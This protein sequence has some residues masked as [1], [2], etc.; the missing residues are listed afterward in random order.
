ML[1]MGNLMEVVIDVAGSGDNQGGLGYG[2]TEPNEFHVVGV[3]EKVVQNKT[4]VSGSQTGWMVVA[5]VKLGHSGKGEPACIACILQWITG[6]QDTSKGR[7]R[8]RVGRWGKEN[9]NKRKRR[10]SLL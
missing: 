7:G 3:R 6:L 1:E 5:F 10:R 2:S 4:Q 9:N 8:W